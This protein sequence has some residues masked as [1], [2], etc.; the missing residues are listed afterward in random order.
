MPASQPAWSDYSACR[1]Q[2]L[3]HL[4]LNKGEKPKGSSCGKMAFCTFC[5]MV[6]IS[7]CYLPHYSM[8]SYSFFS[9]STFIFYFFILRF[10]SNGLTFSVPPTQ[11]ALRSNV[12]QVRFLKVYQCDKGFLKIA[13]FAYL[14]VSDCWCSSWRGKRT[15][16]CYSTY[17]WSALLLVVHWLTHDL[18]RNRLDYMSVKLEMHEVAI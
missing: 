8:L 1:V 4:E 3:Y 13:L 9:A 11:R 15:C 16:T 12:K 6:S 18:L 17:I 5:K 14:C 7:T 2:G 10:N